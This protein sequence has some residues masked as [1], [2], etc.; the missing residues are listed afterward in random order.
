M[1]VDAKV[2]RK[3]D[4]KLW[5]YISLLR[6]TQG[7]KSSNHDLGY[8]KEV[9]LMC[10]HYKMYRTWIMLYIYIFDFQLRIPYWV[11]WIC[12][13]LRYWWVLWQYLYQIRLLVVHCRFSSLCSCPIKQQLLEISPGLL[14]NISMNF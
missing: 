12:M 1:V 8:N 13:I 10:W 14:E 2:D 3:W 9:H 4:L 5:V 7:N 6:P 11:Y